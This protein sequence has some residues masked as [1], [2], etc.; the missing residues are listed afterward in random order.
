MGTM[1]NLAVGRLEVDWGKN[2]YFTDHGPLFQSNDVKPVPTY[3]ANEEWPEGEPVVEM[4]DGFGKP[5]G[6]VLER[7]EL[8]G[9][10]LR[11]V[12][13]DYSKLHQLHDVSEQPIPFEE[14]RQALARVDVNQISGKYREDYDPGE[15]VQKEILER[16][17]LSSERFHYYHPGLRPLQF[18]Q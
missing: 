8:M 2:N 10:T 4:D 1:I 16:L 14:L 5:L 6:H 9:H 12:E 15:F 18:R 13:H 3:Y 7:L 17:A 11:A